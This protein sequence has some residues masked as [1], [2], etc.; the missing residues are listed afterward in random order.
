MKSFTAEDVNRIPMKVAIGLMREAF[1][2]LS[3]GKVRV[4]LRTTV[5]TD[6]RSGVALFMPSYAPAWNLFGL[7]M[8]SVYSGNVAPLPAIQGQMLVMDAANGTLL[9]MLDASAV[10]ALRT[11]AASGLATELLA[12]QEVS[13]LAVFGTGA[14]ARTQVAGVLAARRI[15]QILV[16]GTSRDNENTFCQLVEKEH[17]LDCEPLGDPVN[18]QQADIIC[19]ATTSETPLFELKH[20]KPG[21][22]INAVGAF[23]AHMRELS[24]DIVASSTLVADQRAAVL[25]EAGEVAI[26]IGHG[27]LTPAII[28]A[29][30]GEVVRGKAGR[31]SPDEITVFKSVGNAIQDL[32]VARYLIG[33]S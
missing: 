17:K 15:K 13:T 28:S 21:V 7:K 1:Q 16:K 12:R 19:T 3:E 11:G 23:K 4:P 32:A 26:P 14:Q 31:T 24:E 27:R 33:L 22:H 20:I 6:D 25:H 2:L 30:L 18:L 5:E 29:E 10:T 8:V 9:A